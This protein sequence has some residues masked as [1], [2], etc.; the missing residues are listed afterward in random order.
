MIKKLLCG[1][2]TILVISIQGQSF[3]SMYHFTG[4]ST[5]SPNT[6]TVDPTP[7]PTASGVTFGSFIAVGTPSAPSAGGAFVFSD[8]GIGAIDGND[9][10]FTGTVNPVAYYEVT[11]GPT[12]GSTLTLNSISFNISRSTAGPRHWAVRS[13]ADSYSVNLPASISPANP[14][15]TVQPGNAFFWATDSYSV[16]SGKQL[17]GS[18][19]ALSVAD[20]SNRTTPVTFRFYPWNAETAGGTW[21]LDTVLFSGTNVVFVGLNKLTQ[22]LNSGFKLYPNPNSDA[23]VTLE[24]TK[25][26]FTKVEV[27]NVLGA[28][29]HSQNGIL[30]EKIKLDISALPQGTYFVR[31]TSDNKVYTE[32]L[33]ISR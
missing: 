19:L 31:I 23:V 3:S 12:V 15:L 17:R 18:Y 7:V 2:L 22:E 28:V 14:N 6:G 30:A 32:K 9:I 4:V 25:N 24:V 5:S 13:S 29:V 27:L 10:T 33:I 20:Y 21:R 16:V 1:A 26:N 8:W 11:M